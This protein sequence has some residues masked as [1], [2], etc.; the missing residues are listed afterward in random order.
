MP[1][2]EKLKEAKIDAL[3]DQ[4]IANNIIISMSLVGSGY[5]HLTCATG[6]HR[7]PVGKHLCIDLPQGFRAAVANK[8]HFTLRFNFN[9]PD[10]LEY[11]FNTIG[12]QINGRDL[13]VPFPDY[14]ERIQRRRNFRM[15]PPLDTNLLIKM[16]KVHAIISLINISLGGA[17][18]VLTKHNVKDLQDSLLRVNQSLPHVGIIVPACE[19][20]S[21]QVIIIQRAQV[22]R[23]EHDRENK[24]YR[25]AFEFME[26]VPDELKKLTRCIYNFQRQFLKR[27]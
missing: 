5:E 25:Y 20:W 6:V 1:E 16:G 3:F 24:R 10:K 21:E 8:T 4:L 13:L 26:I 27:R 2:H 23:I 11:L 19:D 15:P 17:F 18:G 22:R 14:V 7:T 12:G 9:G